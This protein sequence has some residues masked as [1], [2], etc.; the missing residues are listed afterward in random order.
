LEWIGKKLFTAPLGPSLVR[1][2]LQNK[3][4]IKLEEYLI[5]SNTLPSALLEYFAFKEVYGQKGLPQ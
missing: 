2:F 3:H 1:L 4:K 5:F